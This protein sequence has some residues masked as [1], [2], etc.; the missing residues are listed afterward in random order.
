MKSST[1]ARPVAKRPLKSPLQA[2][3][4]M[5][6]EWEPHAA[7]WLAWPH[8]ISDWPSK[9]A[10][11]PWVFA[12]ISRHLQ[13]GERIRLIVNGSRMKKRASRA[14]HDSG[15]RLD[16]VDFMRAKT[17]R[18]WTRDFLPTFV[19]SAPR[20]KRPAAFKKR[21]RDG[22]VA[23]KW[24]FNGWARYPDWRLDDEAGRKAAKRLNV[25]LFEPY[26]TLEQRRR[27]FVLEGGAID[28]DGEGTLLA[29][30]ECL[31]DGPQ[32]R[33]AAL[34]RK[35]TEKILHECLGVERVIWLGRGIAGDDTGG[36]ID[37]LC[38]FVGSAKVVL[39]RENNRRD[40]NH[41]VLESAK[42]RLSGARDARGRKIEV[43]R[44]PMPEPV[45]F[46]GQRLPASY[47]NFYIGNTSVLVPTF[48][49]PQDRVALGVLSELFPERRVV[50]IHAG[51]FVLG[52]GTLHCSTQQ[53]PA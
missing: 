18:S 13:E 37:D 40:V 49:D 26:T 24:R 53:E 52:L 28:V 4:R 20:P 11:V 44:L 45:S 50:G 19:V 25:P 33:N 10:A 23:I 1:K 5:P 48:N 47:A 51:D 8:E 9:F 41:R 31:L 21:D 16:R 30:E 39:P 42:E 32:A 12:E 38:R 6:A 29:T 34:G 43:I 14:L 2:G 17:N 27:R 15:V 3:Y 46:A 35:G 22:L 7:T 36:H